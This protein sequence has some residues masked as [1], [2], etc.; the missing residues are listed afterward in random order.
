MK[1]IYG[2]CIFAFFSIRSMMENSDQYVVFVN[3]N[4]N[5]EFFF[6][7][8]HMPLTKESHTYFIPLQNLFANPQ[9]IYLNTHFSQV[10]DSIKKGNFST[11][12]KN[13]L[14]TL[15]EPITLFHELLFKK[16]RDTAYYEIMNEFEYFIYQMIE[17]KIV[18]NKLES[19]NNTAIFVEKEYYRYFLSKVQKSISKAYTKETGFYKKLISGTGLLTILGTVIPCPL[20]ECHKTDY[21]VLSCYLLFWELCFYYNFYHKYN[22]CWHAIEELKKKI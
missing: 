10:V 4:N 12:L 3:E 11:Y 14:L 9:K 8:N 22:E 21:I 5:S 13:S 18:D 17:D 6:R 19:I 15:F 7:I 16:N 1:I 20:V 2:C